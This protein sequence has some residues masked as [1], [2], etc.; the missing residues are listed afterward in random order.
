M[1]RPAPR[2]LKQQP[3]LVARAV[4]VVTSRRGTALATGAALSVPTTVG[5]IALAGAA[6]AFVPQAASAPAAA[7]TYV[8]TA[9]ASK[10]TVLKYGA[11]GSLVKTLQSRLKIS[12]DGS[13]GPATLTKVKGYQKSKGLSVDGVVGPNTWKA[14]GGF[15][16]TTT[17]A[18]P[19]NASAPN[20]CSV[21]VLRYGAKG[22]LVTTMQKRIKATA[23]GS[24]GP[25]TLSAVKKYQ[26]AKGLSADGIVG[27][28]TWSA[29]GGFP[30]GSGGGGGAG[31]D[32][33]TP[34]SSSGAQ[35]KLPF[36]AGASHKITQG[37]MGSFSHKDKYSKYAVD[38]GMSTGSSVV[39]SRSGSVY[40]ASWDAYGGGNSVMVKDSSGYCMQ[41]NHLSKIS[42]GQGQNV[43]Q[44]Q[45]VG[46]A[47]STGNSTG[48]H[49]HWGLVTCSG[50]VSVEVPNS[51]ERGTSYPSGVMATS[52]NG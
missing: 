9:A 24:F 43:T 11:K 21:N 30:C 2:H 51:V 6:D 36:P 14:L 42:V 23:D 37:P 13:F 44:G 26:K 39:A 25:A 20:E 28:R 45:R 49:L 3:S 7:Q 34:P 15:P 4:P 48:P 10:V 41:Y 35:Y 16:G 17:G 12:Q 50:Y 32:T 8:K 22:S 29:L 5:G 46:S 1:S 18:K 31:G 33:G 47:G 27:P 38:F 52:Q 19:G 40:K